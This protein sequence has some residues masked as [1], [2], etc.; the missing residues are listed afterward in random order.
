[1]CNIFICALLWT[2][3]CSIAQG[4][5]SD[6]C[7]QLVV[8]Y[9]RHCVAAAAVQDVT[10][11][12]IIEQTRP[13]FHLPH[14]T[15]TYRDVFT[16]SLIGSCRF[17]QST[18]KHFYTY[19]QC[20]DWIE[21]KCEHT[22]PAGQNGLEAVCLEYVDTYNYMKCHANIEAN[23]CQIR[24]QSLEDVRP[25]CETLYS[26]FVAEESICGGLAPSC[27]SVPEKGGDGNDG[28][29]LMTNVKWDYTLSR[30]RNEI[31]AVYEAICIWSIG[32]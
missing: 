21:Q 26:I 20:V 16:V 14:G 12:E 13:D 31:S 11:C 29:R 6:P 30:L 8:Q 5:E 9:N 3:I 23:I 25:S 15:S 1:M 18:A 17:L 22:P 2:A 28:T 32:L 4:M 7:G 24:L 27:P 19:S 10:V